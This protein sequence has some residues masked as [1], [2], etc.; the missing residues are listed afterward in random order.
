MPAATPL[1]PLVWLALCAPLDRPAVTEVVYDA[2]GDDTGHEFVELHNPSGA[3][4]PL[5][6]VR[7]EAGDG[8]TS[9]RWTLRWTGG[10]G[11]SVRAGARFVI[12]GALVSPPPDALVTL[13]L[14]N[15][16]DAVRLVW[17]DG[18]VETV[19][20]GAHEFAE[21]ACGDPAPDVASGMAL[22]RLPDEARTGSNALDF[23]AATPTPGRA[24]RAQRDVALRAGSLVLAP[25]QPMPG[26]LAVA[27]GVVVNAGALPSSA[28]SIT[29]EVAWADP[30]AFASA[31][32]A[33]AL[34][35]GDSATLAVDLPVP[36]AGAHQ[37]H[38]RAMLAGDESGAN[39]RDSLRVRVGPG[40]LA[41]REIQFHPRAGEGEWVE[42]LNR[43]SAPLDL[44]SFRLSD[45]GTGRATPALGAGVLAPESLAVLAQDRAGLLSRFPALDAARVWQAAPWPALNNSNDSSGVADAVVLL[46]AD[47][48]LVERVDY[49]A[50]GVPDGVPLEWRDGGWWP[51]LAAA[52]TPLAGPHVTL[53]RGGFEIV[54][55]RWHAGGPRPRLTWSLPFASARVSA[56]LY[57]LAGHRVARP[58]H[59]QPAA[60]HGEWTWAGPPPA[61]GVYAVVLR[62][63]SATGETIVETRALRV[64]GEP[65]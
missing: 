5:S 29:L 39:D 24:N 46:E 59:D 18:F 61:P 52:G 19:G 53:A 28:G 43:D 16:P 20:W 54:P 35:P 48:T 4:V 33:A 12:G 21:F 50:G 47:G 62:A 44:A 1:A 6:G 14:Q 3:T 42:V 41:I 64:E 60:A 45:R 27:S 17:P 40:P 32:L 23:A 8:S 51:S 15:G 11:D 13:D 58:F 36:E 30:A 26:T 55:R 37:L 10:A 25:A 57:D 65:R 38:A 2:D 56:E 31:T 22:A 7:L 63:R 9:G 49:S 34:A